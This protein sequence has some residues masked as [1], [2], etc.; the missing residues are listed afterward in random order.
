MMANTPNEL[1]AELDPYEDS[2]EG[3]ESY[4]ISRA[5]M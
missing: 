5:G 2:S 4:G 3:W 1:V